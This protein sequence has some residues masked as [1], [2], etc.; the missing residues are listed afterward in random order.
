MEAA[1]LKNFKWV[2]C[3]QQLLSSG[4]VA[5]L[6]HKKFKVKAPKQ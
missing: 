4:N 6:I 3:S 2:R 1:F 5:C